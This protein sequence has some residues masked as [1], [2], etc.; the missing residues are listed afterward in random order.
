MDSTKENERLALAKALIKFAN[1][2]DE[3]YF[4][5]VDLIARIFPK[6]LEESLTQLVNGPVYDGDVISKSMRDELFDLG[7][8]LRVCHKGEQGYTGATY[9]A[10]SVLKAHRLY[11]TGQK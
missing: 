9:T 3:G 11:A 10:F 1:S 4:E 5:A 6:R 2:T 7:L 8:A